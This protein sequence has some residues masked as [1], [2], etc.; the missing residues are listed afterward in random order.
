MQTQNSEEGGATARTAMA[1]SVLNKSKPSYRKA[2]SES[3]AQLQDTLGQLLL[4]LQSRGGCTS[5]LAELDHALRAFYGP[6]E[7]Q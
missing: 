2:G 7:A 1:P 5:L 4:R 6:C 3:R